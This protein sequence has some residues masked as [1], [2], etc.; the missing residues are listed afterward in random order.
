[1]KW[2][3]YLSLARRIAKRT[4][5]VIA[6]SIGIYFAIVLVGLLPVNNDFLESDQ[7][8][9]IWVISNA[10]HS[11]FVL[12]LETEWMDWREYF[13]SDSFTKPLSEMT[14]CAIGWGDR[15]FFVETPTWADLKIAT[16]VNALAWPSGSC[17]HVD[18][19]KIEHLQNAVSVRISV[20]QYKDL[21]AYVQKSFR[22]ENGK[23][24]R[25][26]NAGYGDTDAFFEARGTYHVFNTCN[27]WI[28][29]G[30]QAAGVR[31]GWFTPLPKTVFLHLPK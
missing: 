18:L 31:T 8:V 4:F 16:A 1:M 19:T 11:D 25:I 2:R 30:L 5:Y 24:I 17:V 10:V 12:P 3:T 14:H 26:A 9:E 6:C 7:G 21:V 15:G 20:Q 22:L 13:S 27:C 29:N 28:G 23:P